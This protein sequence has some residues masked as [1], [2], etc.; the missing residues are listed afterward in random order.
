M[1]PSGDCSLYCCALAAAEMVTRKIN[2][3]SLFMVELYWVLNIDSQLDKTKPPT[4]CVP[5]SVE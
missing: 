2:L 4:K 3:N 5:F 1:L